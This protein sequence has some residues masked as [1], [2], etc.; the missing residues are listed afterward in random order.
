MAPKKTSC[1]QF[2]ISAKKQFVGTMQATGNLTKSANLVGMNTSTAS[3]L[4]KK[5]QKTGTC[6]NLPCSGRPAKLKDCAKHAMVWDILKNWRKP[7]QEIGHWAAE[8]VSESTVWRVLDEQGFHRSVP[9]KVPF[10]TQAQKRKRLQWAQEFV[11]IDE[12]EWIN[13]MPSDECMMMGRAMSILHT[14]LEK[15]SMRIVL[16][17]R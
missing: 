6:K 2:G 1:T 4:W 17:Q 3:C 7:F 10:L 8:N 16:F 5:F 11:D 14:I 13:L 9:W 15:N 12:K